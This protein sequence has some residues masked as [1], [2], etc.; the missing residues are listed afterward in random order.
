MHS[1]QH[2]R[3]AVIDKLG[4]DPETVATFVKLGKVRSHF[5]RE[6]DTPNNHFRTEYEG[7]LIILDYAQPAEH[8]FWVVAKWLHKYHPSISPTA[9][10]FDAQIINSDSVDLKI[11]VSGLRDTYKPTTKDDGTTIIGCLNF[12]A[13]PVLRVGGLDKDGLIVHVA[14]KD[15]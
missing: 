15:K 4:L 12:A 3:Q 10:G 11:T 14:T 8:I 6:N 1:I 5:E 9:I 7:V 2:L 13:D